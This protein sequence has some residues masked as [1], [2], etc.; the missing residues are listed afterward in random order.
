[1]AGDT[2][3]VDLVD[4]A[5]TR[6]GRLIDA[7]AG[8]QGD[9]QGYLTARAHFGA[10]TAFVL[11]QDQLGLASIRP[12]DA[13]EYVHHLAQLTVRGTG[14]ARKAAARRRLATDRRWAT[15]AL[16]LRPPRVVAVTHE[17]R[18][19]RLTGRAAEPGE[20]PATAR[21]RTTHG[22]SAETRRAS[23]L[24]LF[25]SRA[26][27]KQGVL[28]RPEAVAHMSGNTESLRNG[29]GTVRSYRPLLT[30]TVDCR[31]VSAFAIFQG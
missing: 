6:L 28:H 13:T 15:P 12:V 8:G 21:R 16:I 3:F 22:T 27:E 5:A 24:L 30:P 2:R 7:A 1:M 29:G 17:T 26:D 4:D 9:G 25:D 18:A 19:S 20:R 11:L 31:S 10:L 23:R 14:L